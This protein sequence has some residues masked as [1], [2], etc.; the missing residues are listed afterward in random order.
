MKLVIHHLRF[1]LRAL[2]PV[3]LGPQA[4][5]Q[6]RGAFW[7]ALRQFACAA[8]FPESDPEHSQHCPMCRLMAL[9][10]AAGARGVN[11]PRPFAIRPPL[12][13]RPGSDCAFMPGDRFAVGLN[14]Y[15]DAADLFPYVVQAFY[16][17]GQI[18]FGYGR[19]QFT[20]E[21]VE[22]VDPFDGTAADLLHDGRFTSVPGLP[23]TSDHIRRAAAE[24]PPDRIGLRF[25]TPAQITRDSKTLSFPALEG[26]VGRLLERCQAME[27]HYTAEPEPQPVWRDLYLSLTEIAQQVHL[28]GNRTRWISAESGSRRTGMRNSI[29]GFV[30]DAWYEGDL[31]AL[32]P[33]LLWGRSLH[34]GK[35]AVKGNG[36]FE[37][38]LN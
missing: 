21:R 27:L 32:R 28:V 35:N 23:V 8:P 33:W 24:L 30:G 14:L 12:P 2:T 16:R 13:S 3:H 29:S 7:A 17:M 31:S 22:A 11:P 18:G 5:A 36:W 4:G 38:I 34:V 25:L 10:T 9:E 15:G 26:F 19:G 1:H 20:L 37:V 6:I